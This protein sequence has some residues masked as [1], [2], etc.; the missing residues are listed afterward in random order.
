M[1]TFFFIQNQ[2]SVFLN[3]TQSPQEAISIMKEA[4]SILHYTPTSSKR[5]RSWLMKAH[6]NLSC[7]SSAASFLMILLGGICCLLILLCSSSSLTSTS[8]D[9]YPTI[10]LKSLIRET[11]TTRASASPPSLPPMASSIN[12]GTVTHILP[13]FHHHH[14]LHYH[15][16]PSTNKGAVTYIS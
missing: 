13:P 10:N 8:A 11:F 15:Q 1:C 12:K 7:S 4:A 14:H 6:H 9:Y 5:K 3:T 2:A 16:P